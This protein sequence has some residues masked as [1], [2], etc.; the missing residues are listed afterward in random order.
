MITRRLGKTG[1]EVSALSFG[2]IKLPKV[3]EKQAVAALRRAF[4]LGI[5]FYDTARAYKDSE[6]K[7][8]KAFAKMRDKV[9]LATKTT[10]RERDAALS[11]LE[12][13]LAELQT[14]YVDLWQLHSVSDEETFEKVMGP[15]GA[16]EAAFKAKDQGKTRHIGIT[17]HRC[18]KTMVRAI[19]SGVF[20]TLMVAYSPLD[21]EGVGGEILSLAVQRDMG[22][23]IMKP[24]SGG[25]LALPDSLASRP[26][27]QLDPIVF[28]SLRYILSHDAVSAV[29]PGMSSVREV[30]ENVKAAE[31]P[32]PMTE[33]ERREL[34]REIGR[35]GG[36]FRYGQQCLRCGYCLPCPQG[37][38]IPEIFRAADMFRNYPDNLKHMGVELYTSLEHGPDDCAEC[39]E[40]LEKCPAGLNIPE[41]LNEVRELFAAAV[42]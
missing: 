13:S 33:E 1:L 38:N 11:E 12:T 37:L 10:A 29:I 18:H 41:K 22:V 39:G 42:N 8:G 16:I 32:L 36:E 40:C 14:D 4:D 26:E 17:I 7:V 3:D 30:E 35:L 24:L 19:N 28:G 15:G 27:G 25:R 6:A 9:L 2:C 21:Q 31:A 5:N 20:E 23:I 34:M